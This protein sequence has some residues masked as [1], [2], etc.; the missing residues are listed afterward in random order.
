MAMLEG[1]HVLVVGGTGGL[2]MPISRALAARGALLTVSGRSTQKL[3]ALGTELG[4]HVL[5]TVTG[6]L[7][8][9][10]VPGE[11]VTTA[12]ATRPLQGVVFAAGV[13]A[14]GEIGELDDDVLD[15]LVLLNLMAPIRIAR[16]ALA[17]LPAGGFLANISAVVAEQ[18]MKGMAAYCATKAG[19]T[20]FDRAAAA[21]LRRRQIRVVDIRPPHT[22][23]GLAGRPIA[24]APPRLPTGADPAMVA[25]RIVAAIVDD[26]KD[27]PSAAFG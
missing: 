21:E 6:D 17:V 1:A 13:V 19:L 15:Q 5:G 14:F 10:G 18:P 20:A 11:F 7:T 8:L 22:E 23:T 24:G 26:E 12:N 27:L 4:D 25:E 2:G 16:A 3:D 9:P